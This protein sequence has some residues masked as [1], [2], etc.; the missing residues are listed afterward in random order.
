MKENYQTEFKLHSL[1]LSRE[2]SYLTCCSIITFA[3]VL[4]LPNTANHHPRI[5]RILT[6]SEKNQT[7][8]VKRIARRS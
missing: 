2:A 1:F 4:S 6:R 7:F 5:K 8:F 3:K